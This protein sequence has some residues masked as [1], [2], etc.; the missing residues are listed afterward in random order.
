MDELAPIIIFTYNRPEHTRIT[1]EYLHQ[2]TLADQST[3]YAFCDGPKAG[4][5]QA[6]IDSIQQVQDVL[7]SKQWTKEVIIHASAVNKGLFENVVSGIEEV[8]RQYKKCIVIEDDLKIGKGFLNYMNNALRRYKDEKNVKQVS[9]FIFPVQLPRTNSALFLPVT[10]TIGWGT[11]ERAW[12]EVDLDATGYK[13]LATDQ[14]LRDKFNLHG[15]YDY[16][17]MLEKQMQ[18]HQYGSWGI[19]YWWSVFKNNGVVLYPD[20]SL[21]QHNDFDHS[22]VHKSDDSHYN[23]NYWDEDYTIHS[24]PDICLFEKT[25]VH[26]KIR[27]HLQKRNKY[28]FKNIKI[29]LVMI[30][31]KIFKQQ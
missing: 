29:K 30:F 5:T 23:Y 22:G 6:T 12:N 15:V 9:G 4:A 14:A 7:R 3:L 21:I 18:N 11:W 16:S 13:M 8:V 10:N 27:V 24:F 2:C 25:D 20:Y 26:E 17:S 28:S 19:I 1:L 31:N